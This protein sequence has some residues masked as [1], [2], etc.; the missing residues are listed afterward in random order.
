MSDEERGAVLERALREAV[1][2]RERRLHRGQALHEFMIVVE[3]ATEDDLLELWDAICD[4]EDEG[5]NVVVLR[6][7]D[8]AI[9]C[10]KAMMSRFDREQ[11]RVPLIFTQAEFDAIDPPEED[12][13][14][15]D[16]DRDLL[17]DLS[18]NEP[19]EDRDEDG[20]FLDAFPEQADYEGR[21]PACTYG[22]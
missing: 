3:R 7:H 8:S 5:K 12:A 16:D 10:C 11:I 1:A 20:E 21:T 22:G 17:G 9:A 14:A 13:Y 18:S 4:L 15:G 19:F 6:S 2:I